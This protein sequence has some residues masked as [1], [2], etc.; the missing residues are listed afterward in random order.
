VI[1][2]GV[3]AA[4]T[5]SVFGDF[6][7]GKLYAIEVFIYGTSPSA[8]S[9]SLSLSLATNT[10]IPIS[11]SNFEIVSGDTYRGGVHKFESGLIGKAYLNATSTSKMMASVTCGDVTS[12]DNIT[13]AGFFTA[14]E[15]GAI[16]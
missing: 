3:G 14:Q 9:H 15:V 12:S 4:A 10:S 2:G 6:Q 16:S 1:S 5:S 11:F 7:S 8:S 13:L